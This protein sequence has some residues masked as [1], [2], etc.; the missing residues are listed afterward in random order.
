[1]KFLRYTS[2]MNYRAMRPLEHGSAEERRTAMAKGCLYCGLQLPDT[3]RFCPQC[4]R[5]I[6]DAIR[7]DSGVKMRRTT[8]AK[9]CLYCGLQ[10][11]GTA[12]F[13][14]QCG[15]PIVGWLR[16]DRHSYSRT[17]RIQAAGD[18][19]RDRTSAWCYQ[20]PAADCATT[21]RAMQTN[22]ERTGGRGDSEEVSRK[23]R[24]QYRTGG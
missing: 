4:G 16:C 11:P 19:Q 15:R 17:W 10:L 5:P 8:M 6:E 23:C 22:P 9:G 2:Y 14:P 3:T 12:D 20:A 7:V 13:C 21:T 1:V 24:N 18:G